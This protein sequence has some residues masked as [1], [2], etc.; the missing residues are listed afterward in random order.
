M[1]IKSHVVGMMVS[2]ALLVTLVPGFAF[3]SE[4]PETV[5]EQPKQMESE[6]K[7]VEMPKQEE[8]KEAPKPKVE[9]IAK[10]TK[11]KATIRTTSVVTLSWNKVSKAKKYV[12]YKNSKKLSTIKGNSLNVR[13]LN[14]NKKYKF[15]VKAVSAKNIYSSAAKLTVKTPKKI[16]IGMKNFSKTNASKV[17]RVAKSKLRCQYVLG[18]SGPRRFDCSGYVYY[19]YKKS[20]VKRFKRT[21]AQGIYRKLKGH[22]I[23]RT[24]K[25]A[26]PGD[27]VLCGSSRRN[28]SHAAM[29]YGNGKIIHAA[30]PRKDVCISPARYFKVVAV[31]RVP[32]LK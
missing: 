22:Y 16:T 13:H 24:I 6:Q 28:I 10:P 7:A 17:I 18:A 14:K 26:Q 31:I 29:Y 9:K 3:A 8:Q 5:L 15:M 19:C 2:I 32:N 4:T 20:G 12:V 30:N 25:N 27:I 1:S 21:T 11:L 23:G